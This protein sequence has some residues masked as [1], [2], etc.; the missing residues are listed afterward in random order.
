MVVPI[1]FTGTDWATAVEV[2][3]W[4]GRGAADDDHIKSGALGGAVAVVVP[5]DPVVWAASAEVVDSAEAVG[6]VAVAA[7]AVAIAA[8]DGT[9]AG[10][11]DRPAGPIVD[12]APN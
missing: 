6:D 10:A 4:E 3:E 1:D 8:E 9:A 12:D 11:G 7:V 2:P 5:V